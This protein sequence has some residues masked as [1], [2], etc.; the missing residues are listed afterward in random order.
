MSVPIKD[1]SHDMFGFITIML[2]ICMCPI[3]FSEVEASFVAPSCRQITLAMD[4][5]ELGLRDG[6]SSGKSVSR[7]RK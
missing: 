6:E 5:G 2:G 1:H 3:P 4:G 7:K